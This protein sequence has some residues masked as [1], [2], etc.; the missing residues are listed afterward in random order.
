MPPPWSENLQNQTRNAIDE[1]CVGADGK[2]HF[3]H[4]ASGFG[5]SNLLDLLGP[6]WV[7]RSK[8]RSVEWRFCSV[9]E[10]I[11]AGWAVD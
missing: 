9:N 2:L 4:K 6:T 8:S 10:I 7:I 11:N 1:L 5:Y 3:K